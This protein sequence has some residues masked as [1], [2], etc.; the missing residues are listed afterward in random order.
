MRLEAEARL[1]SAAGIGSQKKFGLELMLARLGRSMGRPAR[2][3]EAW[4]PGIEAPEDHDP[5]VARRLKVIRDAHLFVREPRP[6][7]S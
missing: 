4:R 6:H 5:I 1:D 7:G 3:K 2:G